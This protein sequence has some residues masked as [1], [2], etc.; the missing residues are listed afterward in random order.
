MANQ[1]KWQKDNVE[2]N[3]DDPA[4]DNSDHSMSVSA[5]IR[6]QPEFDK[7]QNNF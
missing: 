7:C 5:E 4:S 3:Y 6:G 2:R 1:S